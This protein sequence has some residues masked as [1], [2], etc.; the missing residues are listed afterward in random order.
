[1]GHGGPI[2][3]SARLPDLKVLDY[4]VWSHIKDLIEHKPDGLEHEI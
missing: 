3:W 4:L 2:T 1:M